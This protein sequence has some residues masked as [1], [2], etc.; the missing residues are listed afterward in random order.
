MTNPLFI[1]NGLVVLQ[2][3]DPITM[4]TLVGLAQTAID[5]KLPANVEI[6]HVAVDYHPHE[7]KNKWEVRIGWRRNE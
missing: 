7:K 6:T 1:S 5:A 2:S 3:S 4:D